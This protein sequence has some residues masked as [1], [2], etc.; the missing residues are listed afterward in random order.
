MH[1]ETRMMR[2]HETFQAAAKRA[3]EGT[4]RP[5]SSHAGNVDNYVYDEGLFEKV[6]IFFI[7]LCCKN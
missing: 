4:P 3:Q 2:S 5:V 6:E 7:S 1:D